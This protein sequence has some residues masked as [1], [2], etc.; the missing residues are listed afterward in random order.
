M[1][2]LKKIWKNNNFL[3]INFLCSQISSAFFYR[4]ILRWHSSS[5]N[6]VELQM[7]SRHLYELLKL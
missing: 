3:L 1:I 7:V 2:F 6:K 4:F 5:Q